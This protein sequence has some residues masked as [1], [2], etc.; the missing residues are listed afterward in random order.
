[1]FQLNR[2]LLSIVIRNFRQ[3][4]YFFLLRI[5]IYVF[6]STNYIIIRWHLKSNISINLYKFFHIHRIVNG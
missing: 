4:L 1:M 2:M 5:I 3:Q 6:N